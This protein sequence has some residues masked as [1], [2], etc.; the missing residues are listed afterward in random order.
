MKKEEI[1]EKSKRENLWQDERNK[2]ISIK[3]QNYALLIGNAILL[4][5]ILWKQIHKMPHGELMGIF[6][7]QFAV[8]ILYKYKNKP[9]SKLYLIAGIMMLIAGIIYLIDFFINGVG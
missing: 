6:G 3:S 2:L 9:E 5:V 7:V 4:V 1:L 8:S